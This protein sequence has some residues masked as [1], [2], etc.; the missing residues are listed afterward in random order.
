MSFAHNADAGHINEQN[1]DARKLCDCIEQILL[2]EIKV[3][4]FQGIIPL[5]QLLEKLENASP[6]C[7]PLRNNVGAIASIPSLKTPFSKVRGWIRQS[8]NSNCMDESVQFLIKQSPLM[9][10]YYYPEAVL[11]SDTEAKSFV[12]TLQFW[13]VVF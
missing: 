6:P 4:E 5:W 3:R 10:Q 8:L 11:R 2:N 1:A 9:G 7:I 13:F 12:S